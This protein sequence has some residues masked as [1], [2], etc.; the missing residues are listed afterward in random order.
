MRAETGLEQRRELYARAVRRAHDQA[1]LLWLI[2]IEDIRGM[3]ERLDWR[4]RVD[5]KMLVKEMRIRP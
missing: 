1:C 5:A 4:P 3:S 2:Y